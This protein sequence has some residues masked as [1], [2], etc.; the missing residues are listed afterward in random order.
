MG[1]T[2]GKLAAKMTRR[3]MIASTTF[4]AAGAAPSSPIAA[5]EISN[6]MLSVPLPPQMPA[7]EGLAQLPGT[8]LGYWDTGGDGPAIVLLHPATGSALI[9]GY[10]QPVFARAGYRVIA[11]ADAA[12]CR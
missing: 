12:D 2:D 5:A 10:Q 6:P 1:E 7:R 4:L 8:R 3:D 9:W 11:Y